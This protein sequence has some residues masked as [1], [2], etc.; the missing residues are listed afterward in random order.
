MVLL[1]PVCGVKPGEI[2]SIAWMCVPLLPLPLR[3]DGDFPSSDVSPAPPYP[4][5]PPALPRARAGLEP[6]LIATLPGS[7][8]QCQE[9]VFPAPLMV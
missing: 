8:E 2:K 1:S 7:K 6:A 5:E 4:T 3:L 9:L